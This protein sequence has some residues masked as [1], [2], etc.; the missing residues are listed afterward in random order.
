MD[1]PTGFK[2]LGFNKA[3]KWN[4]DYWS[5]KWDITKTIYWKTTIKKEDMVRTGVGS[6]LI[7]NTVSDK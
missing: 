4:N 6:L 3:K 1:L 5:K 2:Y 7:G